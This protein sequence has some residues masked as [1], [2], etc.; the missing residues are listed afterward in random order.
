MRSTEL[1]PNQDLIGRRGSRK[2]LN[3]P[4][5]ILDLDAFE[6]NMARMSDSVQRNGLLLRPHAKAHKSANVARRQV[7]AGAVGISCANL[8][9]AEVVAD[10]GVES[11]LVTSPV[12]G[13]AGIERLVGLA[14]RVPDVIATVDDA[15]YVEA[16]A[17]H[18]AQMGA[19]L[20][21]LIDVDVGQ[22]R[23]G[24]VDVQGVVDLAR[25]VKATDALR[26]SGLQAYYG[27]LQHVPAYADRRVVVHRALEKL[28]LVTQA[29]NS[30]G[31]PPEIVSGGGTGTFS[32]DADARVHTELQPGSYLFMDRQYAAVELTP[33]HH[34]PFEQSLFVQTIVV[35]VNQPDL[36]VVLGGWKAFATEA[37]VPVVARGAPADTRYRFMGDEH[38]GL[39]LPAGSA[40]LAVGAV[41]ELV[42]P[43]CDP[44][45]NLFSRFH[46]V[47]GDDLVDIWPI[48]ARGY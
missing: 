32:I 29:L 4:A 41:V 34:S 46:C 23:T 21:V 20:R 18:A 27:H 9:E 10:A 35:S 19:S 11:I 37:D 16:L 22:H 25:R 1:G 33:E 43:H 5:L 8:D 47:R 13:P 7:A 15:G 42:P 3:A 2:L 26:Y 36:A 6:R 44:T 38:G 24:V 28:R 40:P 30:A 31:L 17:S 48:E 39:A 45:V 12:G 14:A